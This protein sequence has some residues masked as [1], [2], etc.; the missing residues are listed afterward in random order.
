MT[1]PLPELSLPTALGTCLQVVCTQN[2]IG[3]PLSKFLDTPL[4][5][6]I[7]PHPTLWPIDSLLSATL[8][9]TVK[10]LFMKSQSKIRR[11]HEQRIVFY[12]WQLPQWCSTY[13][14]YEI[15]EKLASW[16]IPQ[17]KIWF[18]SSGTQL[19]NRLYTVVNILL[20]WKYPAS[21]RVQRGEQWVPFEF[22]IIFYTIFSHN[23]NL[24]I[25]RF[26]EE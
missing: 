18:H 9:W 8:R 16:Q 22:L 21:I 13:R 10:K 20:E 12:E 1:K 23:K 4:T 25:R 3:S 15:V 7:R 2:S 26:E 11:A 19:R 6:V 14:L 5:A 24:R 17:A